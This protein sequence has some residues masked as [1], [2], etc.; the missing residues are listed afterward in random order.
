MDQLTATDVVRGAL[1]DRLPGSAFSR[2]D[3]KE[4]VQVG[5]FRFDFDKL[6]EEIVAELVAADYI[7]AVDR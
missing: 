4:M 7:A 5:P 3:G 2:S 6:C 1:S